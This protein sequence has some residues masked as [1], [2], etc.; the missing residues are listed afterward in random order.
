MNRNSSRGQ[1]P[2]P[3]VGGLRCL[4]D[5]PW[6][7]FMISGRSLLLSGP[8]TGSGIVT[9]YKLCLVKD[10]PM[11][12]RCTVGMRKGLFQELVDREDG[13]LAPQNNHLVR[14]WLPGSFMD[15][16]RGG[17]GGEEIKQKDLQT[18]IS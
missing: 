13:R 4:S 2:G 9:E 17:V 10:R 11:N 16:R 3:K 6:P 8:P 1:S 5:L 7:S 12:L 15:Q 18:N 14:A